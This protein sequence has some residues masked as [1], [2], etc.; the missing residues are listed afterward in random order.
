LQKPNPKTIS[1]G[2]KTTTTGRNGHQ[3]DWRARQP[4]INQ[5]HTQ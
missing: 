4:A 1:H 2:A 3:N 5:D